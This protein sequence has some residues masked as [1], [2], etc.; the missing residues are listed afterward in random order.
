M[1]AQE[2]SLR[3]IYKSEKPETNPT[4]TLQ[5]RFLYYYAKETM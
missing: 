4:K 3:Q 5:N 1:H 2:Y